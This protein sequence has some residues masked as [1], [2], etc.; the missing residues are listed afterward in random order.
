MMVNVLLEGP[1]PNLEMMRT[2]LANLLNLGETQMGISS[3]DMG[4]PNKLEDIFLRQDGLDSRLA[5]ERELLYAH[6]ALTMDDLRAWLNH[7]RLEPDPNSTWMNYFLEGVVTAILEERL[8][9]EKATDLVYGVWQ[10][11]MAQ[12]IIHEAVEL[13]A[14]TPW[15]HW[16]NYKPTDRANVQT[17]IVDI[18]HFAASAAIKSGMGAGDVFNAYRAKNAE[19]HAR[20]DGTVPG[21]EDYAA[22]YDAPAT[23]TPQ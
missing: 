11:Q 19:N 14:S 4:E 1:T 18:F 22:R 6:E 20:Q 12:A 16:K 13:Q 21:R 7:R 8:P 3:Y 5:D 23:D 9:V 15:K 10:N 2:A 17:E